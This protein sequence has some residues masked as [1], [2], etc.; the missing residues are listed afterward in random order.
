MS[1]IQYNHIYSLILLILA[2]HWKVE[3]LLFCFVLFCSV[4]FLLFS[5][6]YKGG[7]RFLTEIYIKSINFLVKVPLKLSTQE[8][9]SANILLKEPKLQ[10]CF[11]T[12]NYHI[13]QEESPALTK[14]TTSYNR[15]GNI[16]VQI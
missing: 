10:H 16:N 5:R 4:L 13:L 12:F 9:N 15:I 8:K 1:T 6:F 2:F 14:R 3:N 11:R 7:R